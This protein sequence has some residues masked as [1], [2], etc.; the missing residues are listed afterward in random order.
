[1]IKSNIYIILVQPA[2]FFTILTSF[3]NYFIDHSVFANFHV[4]IKIHPFCTLQTTGKHFQNIRVHDD[5]AHNRLFLLSFYKLNI[6]AENDLHLLHQLMK[7]STVREKREIL[8]ISHYSKGV[9]GNGV[10]QLD[11]IVRGNVPELPPGSHIKVYPY[12]ENYIQT[13]SG[14]TRMFRANRHPFPYAWNHS[15]TYDDK[16]GLMPFL[17]FL[18][19][20][21]YLLQ[22]DDR[23]Q[24]FTSVTSEDRLLYDLLNRNSGMS[25]TFICEKLNMLNAYSRLIFSECHNNNFLKKIVAQVTSVLKDLTLTLMVSFAEVRYYDFCIECF[26]ISTVDHLVS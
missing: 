12:S 24:I 20:L 2:V 5:T 10:L 1:M 14:N 13:G 26:L 15:V 9:D 4:Q 19:C 18:L 22:F 7:L 23:K 3:A 17:I 8:K 21:K 6:A 11:T 16:Y 25:L